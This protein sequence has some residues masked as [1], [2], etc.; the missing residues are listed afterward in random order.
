VSA[1]IS[2][3]RAVIWLFPT[4]QVLQAGESADFGRQGGD[5]VKRQVQALQAGE[6]ADFGRQGGESGCATGSGFAGW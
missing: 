2:G 4:I 6:S 3:G 1:P 5:L